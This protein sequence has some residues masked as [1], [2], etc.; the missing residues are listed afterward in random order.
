MD[1]VRDFTSRE[2]NNKEDKCSMNCMEKYLKLTQRL[3]MRFHEHQMMMTQQE[4]DVTKP[5]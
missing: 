2:L 3:S 5:K 1:C 4:G